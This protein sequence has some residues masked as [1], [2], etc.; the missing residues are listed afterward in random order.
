MSDPI[1]ENDDV[2]VKVMILTIEKLVYANIMKKTVEANRY[3]EE[4]HSLM[5]IMIDNQIIEMKEIIY[6]S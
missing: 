1:L 5:D 4:V 2:L 3:R 6:Q